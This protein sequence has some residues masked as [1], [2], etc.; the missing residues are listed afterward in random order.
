MRS[1]KIPAVALA[2]LFA[3][4]AASAQTG[5]IE[6]QTGVPAIQQGEATKK[7]KERFLALLDD[8]QALARW[9]TNEPGFVSVLDDVRQRL[10]AKGADL[11]PLD[12]YE[13]HYSALEATFS[14]IRERMSRVQNGPE[15]CDPAR[16]DAL[17][18][19][20]VDTLHAEGQRE[21]DARI[22]DRVASL[23]QDPSVPPPLC[24]GTHLAFLS[25]SA[26]HDLVALCD[27]SMAARNDTAG[28]DQ[29]RSDIA[30]VNAQVKESV[31]AA[32]REL[33]TALT[34]VGGQ[35]N[36]VSSLNTTSIHGELQVELQLEIEKA[37]EA[38][39]SYGTIYLPAAYGGQLESVRR[40]VIDTIAHVRDSGEGLNGASGKVAAAD[41][42]FHSG[43][44]KKA[45]RLYSEAY[46][47]AVGLSGQH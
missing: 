45:Y 8:L 29:I 30:G 9:M 40:I 3:V 10:T 24:L 32:K 23:E 34:I 15:L 14:R 5:D 31:R 41:E 39:K 13:Q 46:V 21:A 4:G 7:E 26:M 37:L 42:E 1:K 43:H 25:A 6:T 2:I 19:L 44:Y 38:G 20:F 16:A 27:P 22:C 36:D 11:T 18:L 12:A 35:V 33:T 28:L 17:F 47:A